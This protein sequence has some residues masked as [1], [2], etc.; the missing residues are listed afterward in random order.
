MP[1]E[2]AQGKCG[3]PVNRPL[4]GIGCKEKSASEGER[5]YPQFPLALARG[6]SFC[7]IPNRKPCSQ[8][9]Q[10]MWD[11]A[12]AKELQYSKFYKHTKE[13][14]QLQCLHYLLQTF[15]ILHFTQ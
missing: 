9:T 2:E 1:R 4:V 7:P 10:A 13:T 6:L 14:V 12:I 11:D 8:A 3:M 5:G 15:L